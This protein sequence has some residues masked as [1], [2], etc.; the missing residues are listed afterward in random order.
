[1]TALVIVLALAGTTAAATI[2]GSSP[3]TAIPLTGT[4]SSQITGSGAGSYQYFSIDYPGGNHVGTITFF[5]TPNDPSTANAFGINIYQDTAL[6][7]QTNGTSSVP[8]T[9]SFTFQSP[10]AGTLIAQVHNFVVGETVFYQLNLTG[11]GSTTTP[12]TATAAAQSVSGSLVGNHAGAY[13]TLTVPYTAGSAQAVN[14]SFSPNDPAS[15]HGIF[16]VAYQNGKIISQA[17]AADQTNPG[18][19]SFFYN[20]NTSGPV[21]IQLGNYTDGLT[22]H[23]TLTHT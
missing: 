8:G 2:D 1:M 5:F 15:A 13:A 22:I 7:A 18:D 14:V 20:S 12:N 9:N 19:F 23:F 16:V 10:T 4:F 21:L 11:L 3:A 17:S 6:I